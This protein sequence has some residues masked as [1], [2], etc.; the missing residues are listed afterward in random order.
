MLELP[1][2]TIPPIGGRFAILLL[3]GRH[4]L[5]PGIGLSGGCDAHGARCGDEGQ[6]QGNSGQRVD[7]EKS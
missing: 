1:T 3:E 4:V 5:G 7:H 6:C 2:K